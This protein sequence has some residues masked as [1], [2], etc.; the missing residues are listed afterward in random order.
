[1]AHPVVVTTA[2]NRHS[3]ALIC[4]NYHPLTCGVGDNTMRLGAELQRRGHR[5]VVFTHA[6]AG[7]H[8][9]APTVPVRT[10][11]D[12]GPLPIASAMAR[13]INPGE[14]S[15]AI[16]QYA[17]QMWGAS[18]FGSPA[19]PLLT[20]RLKRRG[21]SV[22]LILHE[23]F[24]PWNRRPDL[25]IGAAL[26]RAQLG[27]VMPSCRPI[28][29][30]TASRCHHIAAAAAALSPP[31]EILIYRI[32]SGALPQRSRPSVPGGHRM[33]LFSSLA[34]GKLFDAVVDAFEI[35][36]RTYPDAELLLL[37]DLGPESERLRA[38]RHRIASS[39]VASRIQMPGKL[40]LEEVARRVA[41]LDLYLFPMGTGA[42][43]RSSTLP[44]ALGAGIPV[45]AINGVE[46]DPL[47]VHGK[48]I[49]F[50]ESL[51]GPAFA[52]A[53][54]AI[55]ADRDLAARLAAGGLRLYDEHL[56]WEAI[57][58]SL[59]KTLLAPGNTVQTHAYET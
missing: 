17:P 14:F 56:T 9:E 42:N 52:R 51:T 59:L 6:P 20:A 50:A 54:A 40:P 47:F 45:V 39:P 27:A 16:I 48:N 8:P 10:V 44:L 46:T 19:L 26:L 37:G 13:A 58:D 4:P 1:M 41:S 28:Y 11:P 12:Q 33:G 18:R 23:L 29:V 7:P 57:T 36:A 31:Q 5:A 43:T 34:V 49:Y 32:G 35:V 53:S 25:A 3:F 38:L 30:T 21:L 15:H 2:G 55:F 22:A 24:T